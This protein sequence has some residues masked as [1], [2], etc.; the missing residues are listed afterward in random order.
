M[1]FIFADALPINVGQF[2]TDPATDLLVTLL[3]AALVGA[4]KGWYV[5][6]FIYDQA[7]LR[8]DKADE[9]NKNM[10]EALKA[11]TEEIRQRKGNG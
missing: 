11:L 8:A 6:R 9:A 4:Y 7:V 10:T 5:P 3:I 1:I 2:I